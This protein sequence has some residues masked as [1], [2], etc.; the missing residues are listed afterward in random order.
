MPTATTSGSR[1]ER[2]AKPAL[3]REG[4]IAAAVAVMRAEGLEHVTMRRLAAELDTG[5]ASLYVY[6]RNTDELHA[7]V[8]DEMLALV[9]FVPDA[10]P[11]QWDTTVVAVLSSYTSILVEHP[12]LARS[13]LVT[14][15]SGPS[16]L[17]LVERL[18][19]LLRAGGVPD[20]QA[21]WGIDLLLLFAT[22]IALEHGTRRQLTGG[23]ED[24]E[25]LGRAIRQA[26]PDTCPTIVALGDDL[27]SGTPEARFGWHVRVLLAGMAATPRP[28]PEGGPERIESS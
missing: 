7:A 15:P 4:I 20:G 18:L 3:S 13:A 11:A 21:A 5:P 8:L 22:S 24:E 19:S 1:R 9:G 14:R 6:V 27:L 12:G 25:A 23:D 16:Y 17:A 10:A 28:A 2:P 26:S